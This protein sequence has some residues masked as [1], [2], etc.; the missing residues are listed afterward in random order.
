M[1]IPSHINP[2]GICNQLPRAYT[3]LAFLEST[4]TQH[5]ETGLPINNGSA[6]TVTCEINP[7]SGVVSGALFGAQN[8]GVYQDRAGWSEF[9]AGTHGWLFWGWT[10][11][12]TVLPTPPTEWHRVE[13]SQSGLYYN[14]NQLR[15]LSSNRDF[16]TSGSCWLF[17]RNRTDGTVE[18]YH[19]KVSSFT[20]S[21]NGSPRLNF[22]PCV[23][24][25]GEPCMFDK[26]SR[27]LYCNTGT[28][29]FVAGVGSVEQLS[30][31]LAHLPATGGSLTLSL[32]AEGNTPEVADRLQA[33][34]DS[35]G[36]AITVHEYR[37]AAVATYSLRRMRSVVWCRAEACEHGAYTAANGTRCSIEYCAAI[38]GEHGNAPSAYGYDPF[39]SVQHAVATWGLLSQEHDI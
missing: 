35:K 9:T 19:G 10:S 24:D 33:C 20:F 17:A 6:L 21:Q 1:R 30:A 8:G 14:G 15:N 22:I 37:P 7:N 29:K 4:G 5:I 12:D 28:G 27:Q 23:D 11:E 31:L 32:P 26:V 25:K 2:L 39:D 13:L 38:F 16:Q 36:W 34:H 3:P 18:K